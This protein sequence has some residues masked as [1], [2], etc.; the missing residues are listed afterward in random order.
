MDSLYIIMPA[1]NEEENIEKVVEQWYPVIEEIGHGSRLV[2]FNDGSKDQTEEKLLRL[3]EKYPHL[4]GITKENEGHGATLLT[5]Y[6]YAIFE[7]ADYVF[8]T[9]SDGQTLPKEFW[10]LW[11]ERRRCGLLLG[12][13][14]SRQDGWKRIF[15]TH[16][17]KLVLFFRYQIWTKDA[18]VPF[19]LMK[20][21][22]LRQVLQ[23]IPEGFNLSNVLMTVIYEKQKLGVWYYPI[24]FRPR[25]GGTNSINMKKIVKI[26]KQ[27]WKDFHKMKKS[28]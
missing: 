25:Q 1:Y 14:K 8:Q 16:V 26:G 28:I 15:V 20:S 19:R 4:V 7:G 27:A 23:S 11:R 24:T 18:N 10:P 22:Q 12:Y 13:R 3:E 17:L 2:V 5:G 6:K 21:S 9:D